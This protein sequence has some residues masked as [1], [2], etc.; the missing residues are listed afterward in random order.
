MRGCNMVSWSPPNTADK[1]TQWDTRLDTTQEGTQTVRPFMRSMVCQ[2]RATSSVA[3]TQH[4]QGRA[5]APSTPE[6]PEQM[7]TGGPAVA[8]TVSLLPV[9][10]VAPLVPSPVAPQEIRNQKSAIPKNKA[11]ASETGVCCER[12]GRYF[13][14]GRLAQRHWWRQ[15]YV[16]SQGELSGHAKYPSSSDKGPCIPVPEGSHDRGDACPSSPEGHSQPM[17][18]RSN[19]P[20]M[21]VCGVCG[22]RFA[23]EPTLAAHAQDGLVCAVCQRHFSNKRQLMGHMWAHERPHQCPFCPKR[24]CHKGTL[25]AHMR[26]HKEADLHTCHICQEVFFDRESLAGHE[27][28]A[29]HSPVKESYT[30]FTCHEV[31]SA[32]TQLLRHHCKVMLRRMLAVADILHGAP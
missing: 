20:A 11:Y 22:E 18:E 21:H 29:H 5:E 10:P 30:C 26:T 24:L 23:S 25:V 17:S 7:D 32:K 3:H 13:V 8:A 28:R 16:E 6:G 4:T 27:K 1:G 2:T 14:N 9:P 12:C 31:F 19:E 15:H